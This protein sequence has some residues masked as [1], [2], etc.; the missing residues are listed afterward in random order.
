MATVVIAQRWVQ[1]MHCLV[2]PYAAR[3]LQFPP[4]RIRD[5]VRSV[6]AAHNLR[7]KHLSDSDGGE[8][9]QPGLTRVLTGPMP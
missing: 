7:V 3:D 5:K 1:H 9:P 2:M 8:E 6:V 4:A